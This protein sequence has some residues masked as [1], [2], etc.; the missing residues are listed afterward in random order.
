LLLVQ[1][2]GLLAVRHTYALAD[3]PQVVVVS[4]PGCHFSRDAAMAISKDGRLAE[5]M[6]RTSIWIVPQETVSNFRSIAQW[7]ET[8]PSLPMEAV[9][10]QS[11]WSLIPSWQTPG[12]Y[13]LKN[14]KIVATVIGWPGA[15]QIAKLNAAFA[16][17]GM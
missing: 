15:K 14:G 16:E 13:F 12:F 4:S 9:F 7:N 2:D 1:N 17:L 3:R 5:L 8:Y 10:H 11:E 6:K